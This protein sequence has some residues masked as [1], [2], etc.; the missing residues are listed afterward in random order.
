MALGR[1]KTWA[2]NEVLTS[3]DL[4]AEFNNILNNPISLISP[5]PSNLDFGGN[6]AIG[7]SAGSAG[8]PSLQFTGDTNTGIYSSGAGA[9][10]F[11]VDNNDAWRINASGHLITPT[12][13]TQDIGQS[14]ATRPR[15][16]YH[17]GNLVTGGA[18]TF[19]GALSATAATL[20]GLTAN[21]FLYS[22]TAGL[23]TTTAAP[24]NGQLLIGST[25]V[26]PVVATPTASSGITATL[27]A[28]SLAFTLSNGPY[29]VFKTADETVNASTTLQDDDH[30]VYP[31]AANTTYFFRLQLLLSSASATPDFKVGWTVPAAGAMFWG[32]KITITSAASIQAMWNSTITQASVPDTLLIESDTR[33]IAG[34]IATTGAYFEGFV[35]NGANSGNLQLQWAQQTSNA[36]DSKVLK[37]SFLEI[38][39]IGTT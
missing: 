8:S 20:S 38:I 1:I 11:S 26:A 35:R 34:A 19:T 22:G 37:H 39:K 7:L 28:G 36:S 33:I 12:D 14:G 27:G 15:H 18:G 32:E 9:L 25:G 31:V 3:S 4:N 30:L 24:T 2:A 13:A 23:L 16:I 29:Y 5:L 10:D 21:S 17:S 6:K